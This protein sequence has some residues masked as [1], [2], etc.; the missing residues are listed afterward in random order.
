V[1]KVTHA[2]ALL[3]V[4]M[5]LAIAGCGGGDDNNSGGAGAGGGANESSEGL[6]GGGA[7]TNAE[8]QPSS[9][10]PASVSLANVSNLGMVLVDS[11]GFT[12]YLFAKDTGTTSTCNGACAQAWPPLTTEGAP[13]AGNG[14]S[15]PELG[16]S[17]RSDGSVQVT[18]AGHPVYTYSADTKPGEANG[19][20]LTAFGAVWSVL[21]AKGEKAG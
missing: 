4:A 19:N 14:A 10:G 7:E 1:I 6:Y 3:A 13:Q 16:T 2:L 17:K 8:T 9:G 18:Y 21:N 12:L 11:K 15:A 5:V 20:G